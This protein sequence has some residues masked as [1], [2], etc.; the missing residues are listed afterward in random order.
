MFAGGATAAG[1]ISLS[2]PITGVASGATMGSAGLLGPVGWLGLGALF[3]GTAIGGVLFQGDG[4]PDQLDVGERISD[5]RTLRADYGTALPFGFGLQRIAGHVMWA[6]RVERVVEESKVG[7][8]GLFSGGSV[9]TVTLYRSFAVAF[10]RGPIVEFQKVFSG[11]KVLWDMNESADD[12]RI[13]PT[14][15]LGDEDQEADPHMEAKLGAGEVPGYRG[16]AYMVVERMN[17]TE[18]SAGMMPN[19]MAQLDAG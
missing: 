19:F 2:Q 4:P 17:M 11:N 3:L 13:N 16:V 15:Y 6:D 12:N 5:G 8:G 14:F 18:L 9:S 10:L 7:K 1:P